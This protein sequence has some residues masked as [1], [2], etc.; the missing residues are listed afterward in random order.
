MPWATR[1][2]PRRWPRSFFRKHPNHTTV[3]AILGHSL[4]SQLKHEEAHVQILRALKAEPRN[5]KILCLLAELSM[6]T[7]RYRD[8]LGQYDKALKYLPDFDAAIGGKAETYL[9]MGKP[10]QALRVLKAAGAA[11]DKLNQPSMSKTMADAFI[12]TG[13]EERRSPCLNTCCRL[14]RRS[15]WNN[16]APSCSVSQPPS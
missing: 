1:L 6:N 7:G 8:A 5:P 15:P 11:V 10:K 4:A 16:D 9:R 3:R 12:R 14:T 2:G 13:Q